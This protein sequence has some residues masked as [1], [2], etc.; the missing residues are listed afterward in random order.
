MQFVSK[1]VVRKGE[2]S[3]QLKIPVAHGE[4]RYYANPETLK[5]MKINR[6]ILFYYCDENGD[7]NQQSNP[8]GSINNIAGICNEAGNVFGMMPHPERA[9]SKVLGND[10]GKQILKQLFSIN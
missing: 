6:Q 8:N 2:H 3:N 5:A 10:D 9:C 1:S 7:I 4:G